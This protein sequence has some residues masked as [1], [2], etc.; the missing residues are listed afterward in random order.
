MTVSTAT[1][2]TVEPARIILRLCK[3]WGHKFAVRYDEQSGEIAL[4]GYGSCSM[5][6]VPGGLAFRL[7]CPDPDMLPRLQQVVAE[8]AQRMAR[9][10]TFDFHWAAA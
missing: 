2:R 3:H 1:I 6:Q 10:E 9:D 4:T 8:H 5:Q 7:H